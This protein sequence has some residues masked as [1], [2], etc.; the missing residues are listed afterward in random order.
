MSW[1]IVT[2]T[3]DGNGIANG[4]KL[5]DE[6]VKIFI[7]AGAPTNAT[8]YGNKSII[9]ENSYWFSPGAVEIASPLLELFG[10]KECEAPDIQRLALLVRN[11]GA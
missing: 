7:A 10:A 8:M 11:S 1:K 9:E 6:F 2:L 5:Q 4:S 3:N